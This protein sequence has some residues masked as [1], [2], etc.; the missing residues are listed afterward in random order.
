MRTSLTGTILIVDDEDGVR[1]MLGQQLMALGH[2]ILEARHGL[3]ALHLVRTQHGRVDVVL[4]D[5]VM[6]HLNGTQLAA[7][8][9]GE[10]PQLPVIL[11]SAYAP[12][13]LTRVGIYQSVVPVLVKP[14]T[15]DEVSGL[16]QIA[17]DREGRLVAARP[18]AAE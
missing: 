13:A 3:E 15:N 17:L 6:P 8:L 12:R 16:I 4:T 10:F 2:S 9:I 14:F 7:T 11:M 18:A 5:V 1:A